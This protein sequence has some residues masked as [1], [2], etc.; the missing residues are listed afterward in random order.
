MT[1]DP[2]PST[3]PEHLAERPLQVVTACRVRDLP[4]LEIAVVRLRQYLPFG[5]LKVVAPNQ[6]CA[7][8]ASRLEGRANVI[9]E[10]DFVPDLT[11]EKLRG[12]QIEGFPKV[13]GWYLQQLLKLQFAFVDPDDDY[14]LI[15]DADTV[16]LRPLRFFNPAGQMLLTKAEEYHAPYFATYRS[17]LGTEPNRQFS[18]IAQH[19]LVQKSVARE[20]MSRIE[21][22]LPGTG[23]WAWKLM[24]ALPSTGKNLFSEYETYGHYIKN[25]YPDRV[26]FVD[27]PWQRAITQ[28]TGQPIPTEKKLR[29][30]AE[31]YEY[32]AFERAYPGWR[33][34]AY[35][36]LARVRSRRTNPRQP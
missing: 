2:S 30:L 11:I 22:H 4:V 7:R 28:Y 1:K 8:I 5:G 18:F 12:L 3:R 15:W 35:S 20:M 17:L 14:Y 9:P 10:N 23:N 26:V 21:Q 13:A 33:R 34:L 32:A 6:D 29:D 36:L 31:R 24:R 16:P 25:H 27:R 19:M